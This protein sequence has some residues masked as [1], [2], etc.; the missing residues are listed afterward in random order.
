MGMEAWRRFDCRRCGT[1]LTTANEY[2]THHGGICRDCFRV[3]MSERDPA[4]R[5][6]YWVKYRAK[7][8]EHLVEIARKTKSKLKQEV[9][10]YYS[11]GKVVCARCGY[12]DIRALGLDHVNGGGAKHR[13]LGLAGNGF[14]VW[15][16][17]NNFPAGLQ[18]LC[19]NCN[20]VKRV[21]ND[22]L[23]RPRLGS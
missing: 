10:S 21:E 13:R 12:S 6:N 8:G 9:L 22:E 16:K 15:L 4:K 3:S 17:K 19:M 7:N 18:V 2:G 23:K 5:H 1:A 14:Y 11:D 20:W